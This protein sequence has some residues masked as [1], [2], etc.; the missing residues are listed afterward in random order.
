MLIKRL[1]ITIVIHTRSPALSMKSPA[2]SAREAQ[3]SLIPSK[4]P[5]GALSYCGVQPPIQHA[6]YLL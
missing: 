3:S 5:V 2:L 1:I 4:I 6:P